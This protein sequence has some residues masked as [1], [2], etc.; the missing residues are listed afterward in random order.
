MEDFKEIIKDFKS[1]AWDSKPFDRMLRIR[2]ESRGDLLPFLKLCLTEV[3]KGGTFVDAAFSYISEE[4]F[5]ELIAYAIFEVKCHGWTDAICSVVDYASLQFPLLL[6][7]YLPDL[8][9]SRSNTYYE[10]WA[11]RKA[12]GK[13]VGQ[14]LEIID[15]GGRLKNYAWECLVNVRKK[16]AILKAHELFEKGCPRPQIGF[17]T[18]SME[19]GFVVRDGDARQLYRDNT[20]HIIFNE[21]YITELD[22]GVVDSVN[23]A[24]LSRRNH[25]T[26]AIKGGDV[27][28]YT[29]GGVS[30]SSCGSCG[31]SLH[32]LI[33]I[34]DNLLGNSGL[35]SLA[36][37]LS[38]LGWE[39]ERLFYKHNSAGVPTPLKINEDHCNPEFKSLPLKRTKIKIVRT[40]ER[41]EFQDWGLANSR[42]NLNRVLGSP[43]WIQGA[44]YPSC[45]T[46]NEVMMF[47]AQLDSNLLLENDQE[48][49]WGSG[50]IC[51]IFWCASCDVSGV[52]WQCT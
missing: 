20:Y 25:P 33:D 24:A 42:E 22:Q 37:C 26:W 43:T 45:P 5:K 46:C 50:G 27:Q 52:F 38:C 49:L 8:L 36:T 6:I 7:E 48:W 1:R 23:Y 3:P 19:S 18:Y 35:V 4:E 16:T 31:G 41:W 11:W 2:N 13:Q 30:Q 39:E 12:G 9:E 44:E 34:P 15:S 28:V 47:C 14:L 10:K 21:E 17:D 29:F 40:P 32:H 51:Y